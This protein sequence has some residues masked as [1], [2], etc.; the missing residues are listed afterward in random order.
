MSEDAKHRL[1]VTTPPQHGG[2][3]VSLMLVGT[4]GVAAT[5]TTSAGGNA[6][7]HVGALGVSSQ[8][9]GFAYDRGLDV[10][11]SNVIDLGAGLH[12]GTVVFQ[13]AF[14]FELAGGYRFH[15]AD[16]H[17]PFVRGGFEALIGGNPL[18][19]R[20]LLELP[21]A[22]LGYQYL[23]PTAL[24][25][26][27][28]RAGLSIFGRSDMG[29]EASHHLDQVLDLGGMMTVKTGPVWLSGEWSHFLPRDGEVPV[30]WLTVSLCGLAHGLAVCTMARSVDAEGS[31]APDGHVASHAVQVGLT[32]G[33]SRY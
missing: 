19:Y 16:T 10:R 23:S 4:S 21:Q 12:D 13:G 1:A 9:E 29:Y 15:V 8:R 2:K 5:V 17:G 3:T 11:A 20:S 32:I 27:A 14:A 7:D 30:D 31:V 26:V 33:S 22:Q 28:G 24:V 6:S 25:E 18:V